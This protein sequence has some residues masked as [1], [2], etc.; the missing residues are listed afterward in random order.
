LREA[1]RRLAAPVPA[2]VRSD[3][4]RAF[5]SA[6]GRR[7]GKTLTTQYRMLPTIGRIVSEVFYGRRLTHGRK[8]SRVPDEA[9]PELLKDEVVWIRTDDLG[10]A[11]YQKKSGGTSLQNPVEADMIVDVVLALDDHEPFTLWLSQQVEGEKAIGI[12][13]TYAEQRELIRRRL[14]AAGVSGRLLAACKIDTVDSYQGK[15]NAIVILSLVRNNADGRGSSGERQIA[16]G[17]MTR[18]NRI[19]VAMSRAMDRLVMV[20]ASERWPQGSPMS[21]VAT[22]VATLASEGGASFIDASALVRDRTGDRVRQ[23]RRTGRAHQ[24]N[25]RSS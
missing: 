18:G 16:Q 4:E 19:N 1:S 2:L 11:A 13:C 14:N 6:Y 24:R 23:L 10:E 25:V 5:S 9:L 15:E 20:G 7:V 21:E 3:F 22:C 12:I 8:E 17:Y